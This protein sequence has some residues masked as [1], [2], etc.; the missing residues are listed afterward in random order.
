[1]DIDE[2][3]NSIEEAINERRSDVAGRTIDELALLKNYPDDGTG[4]IDVLRDAAD[5]LE[6]FNEVQEKAN[7]FLATLESVLS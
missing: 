3:R 4:I 2:I 5:T 1:M 6:R 7:D